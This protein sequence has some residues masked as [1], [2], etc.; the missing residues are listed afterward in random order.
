[1]REEGGE[2]R[3]EGGEKSAEGEGREVWG[4]ERD[5]CEHTTLPGK[6]TG[7]YSNGT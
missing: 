6:T 7:I 3:E 5:E 2:R 4:E 1:M